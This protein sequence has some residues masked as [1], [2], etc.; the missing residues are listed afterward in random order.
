MLPPFHR[1]PRSATALAER[2]S[3]FIEQRLAMEAAAAEL[4]AEAEAEEEE[5]RYVQRQV[6]RTVGSQAEQLGAGAGLGRAGPG[7]GG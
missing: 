5:A 7:W 6:R 3:A 1:S 4:E 2:I